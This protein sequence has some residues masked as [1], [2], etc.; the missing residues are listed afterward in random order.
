MGLECD[1]CEYDGISLAPSKPWGF[2]GGEG[3]S[4][5]SVFSMDTSC[6]CSV[7]LVAC[8]EVSIVQQSSQRRTVCGP[9]S[10]FG[11]LDLGQQE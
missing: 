9:S 1:W 5:L 10:L 6:Q 3:L 2:S 8:S 4:D 7:L 11:K